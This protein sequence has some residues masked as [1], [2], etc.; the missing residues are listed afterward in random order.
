MISKTHKH[1][2]ARGGNIPGRSKQRLPLG[3]ASGLRRKCVG[4]YYF[5][6]QLPALFTPAR[7][8]L[9][10]LASSGVP[11]RT[12]AT[13]C[14]SVLPADFRSEDYPCSC[15][16]FFFAAKTSPLPTPRYAERQAPVRTRLE[17]AR[18][19][20]EIAKNSCFALRLPQG[21]GQDRCRIVKAPRSAASR[22]H[23][24][25]TCWS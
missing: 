12:P 8:L 5:P 20:A 14:N 10:A 25:R 7:N 9:A 21:R 1:K 13:R 18:L 3:A 19:G 4:H 15:S 2:E 17:R 11:A 16:A 23:Q 22:D 6:D 24:G